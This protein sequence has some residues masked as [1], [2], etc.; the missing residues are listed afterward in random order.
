M[1]LDRR[2]LAAAKLVRAGSPTVDIGTDHGYLPVYLVEKGIVSRCVACDIHTAPLE[3]ARR[4][5][6]EHGLEEQIRTLLSDGLKEV[7]PAD[8]MDILICGMGGEL[9]TQI[10]QACSWVRDPA[11]RLILQPMTQAPYLREWLAVNGFEILSETP[12]LDRNHRYTVIHAEFRGPAVF[13]DELALL[14]GRIP[15]YSSPEALA[16]VEGEWERL[17]KIADGQSQSEDCMQE[18]EVYRSL[19]ER[20][21]QVWKEMKARCQP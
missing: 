10:L 1:T 18:A 14:L 12:V 3:S 16:Y 8:G 11:R 9:I 6:A 2:L 7:A 15:E 5:I 17:R 4:T 21:G 19:S 20:V 13:Q